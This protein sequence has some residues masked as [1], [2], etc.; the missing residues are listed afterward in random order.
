MIIGYDPG[1][2]STK[3]CVGGKTNL[4]QS[5]VSRPREVG[6]AALGLK[7]ARVTTVA[8]ADQR[9]AVGPGSWHKGTPITSMDY[10]ALATPER[11]AL[12]Y[13]ALSPLLPARPTPITLV[14]GLPVPLL[15]DELQARPVLESLKALKGEHKFSVENGSGESHAHTL[16]IER[17]RYLPQPVGAYLD[18]LYDRHLVART[19]SSKVEV[20]M[21]DIGMNTFDVYVLVGGQVI[22]KYIGG[23][24]IGVKRLLEQ[25]AHHGRDLVE[26]DAQLRAGRLPIPKPLLTAWL[27]ETLAH[28]KR[29]LPSL[30]RFGVTIPCGGGAVV[31]GEALSTALVIRGAVV[32]WPTNPIETNVSGFWKFGERK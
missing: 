10:G 12:F 18:W 28:T 11:L 5:A 2:G 22:E 21:L 4:I 19:G 14:V 23:A 13:G 6:L 31:L 1:Y 16:T 27:D 30:N 24:E 20:A 29:I 7:S 26:L 17:I 8:F 25:V 15:Q 9:F 3:V 32:H